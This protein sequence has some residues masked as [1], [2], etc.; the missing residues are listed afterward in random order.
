MFVSS[1]QRP[2]AENKTH[3][4][5]KRLVMEVEFEEKNQAKTQ[6]TFHI[7]LNCILDMN[8]VQFEKYKKNLKKIVQYLLP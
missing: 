1:V 4:W 6:M 3:C 2:L 5:L 7:T 8:I